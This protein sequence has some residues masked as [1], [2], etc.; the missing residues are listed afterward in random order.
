MQ[1]I[2]FTNSPDNIKMTQNK[3]VAKIDHMD[4][5]LPTICSRV[6]S[7]IFSSIIRTHTLNTK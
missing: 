1:K 2:G 6:Y 4:H 7:V 5:E 3:F